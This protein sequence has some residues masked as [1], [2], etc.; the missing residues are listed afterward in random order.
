MATRLASHD[1][2]REECR[3]VVKK[4]FRTR[5]NVVDLSKCLADAHKKGH[6]DL[7]AYLS[8]I[9]EQRALGGVAQN[10]ARRRQG[11]AR[12]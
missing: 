9:M 7:A 3:F 1:P 8:S 6:G 5:P 2:G 12:L 4:T 11:G 10:A